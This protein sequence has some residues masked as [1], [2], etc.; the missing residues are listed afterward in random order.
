MVVVGTVVVVVVVVVVVTVVVGWASRR[1]GRRVSSGIVVVVVVV[2]VVVGGTQPSTMPVLVVRVDGD[3]QRPDR[4]RWM[5]SNTK[6]GILAEIDDRRPRPRSTSASLTSPH[7]LLTKDVVALLLVVGA[8][9]PPTSGS[10]PVRVEVRPTVEIGVHELHERLP[11]MAAGPEPPVTLRAPPNSGI[12]T[13]RISTSSAS[14][15]P[16]HTA[17]DR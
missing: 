16:I 2:V 12:T 9:P 3:E 8:E 13:P 14:G 1:G 15:S 7:R 17:V 4:H 6:S 5:G 11:K 10:A